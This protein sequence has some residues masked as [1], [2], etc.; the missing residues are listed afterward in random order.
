MQC[1]QIDL[2]NKRFGWFNWF[3]LFFS[4][5]LTVCASNSFLIMLLIRACL[6]RCHHTVLA[7]QSTHPFNLDSKYHIHFLR[8]IVSSPR[9]V[10]ACTRTHISDYLIIVIPNKT[11]M[12]DGSA[13]YSF[14]AKWQHWGLLTAL[15]NVL[16]SALPGGGAKCVSCWYFLLF[17]WLCDN[18]W[19]ELG[20]GGN[21]INNLTQ[22]RIKD[23]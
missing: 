22:N 16:P 1:M 6:L 11:W 9:H 10:D 13:M 5:H 8:E 21:H 14:R 7:L 2:S 17:M 12:I 3:R 19:F 15:L 18:R 4:F 20:V 23:L